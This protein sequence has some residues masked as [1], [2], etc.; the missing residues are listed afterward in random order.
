M[1]TIT[2]KGNPIESKSIITNTTDKNEQIMIN[3][4]VIGLW[5]SEIKLPKQNPVK[6]KP[7]IDIM[8]G[9]TASLIFF[10]I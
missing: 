8:K 3:S 7:R 10:I 1:T 6:N 2:L 4:V 5:A 9:K